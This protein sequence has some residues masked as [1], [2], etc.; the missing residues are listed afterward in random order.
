MVTSL[1]QVYRI[2]RKRYSEAVKREDEW[3]NGLKHHRDDLFYLGKVHEAEGVRKELDEIID[4]LGRTVVME[5]E[6]TGCRHT[7]VACYSLNDFIN[8]DGDNK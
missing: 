5:S 6:C 2:L 1:C 4:I 7:N 3:R 8:K